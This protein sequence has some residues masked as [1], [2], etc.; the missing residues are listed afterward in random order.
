MKR[1]AIIYVVFV[2]TNMIVII[3][4]EREVNKNMNEKMEEVVQ[5]LRK[6]FRGSIEFYDVP[7]KEQYKIEYC[8]N[9]LYIV[10]YLHYDFIDEKNIKDIVLSLSISI[11]TQIHYH[12]YK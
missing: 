11:A 12:Y 9:G 1:L 3:L 4:Q 5:E 8:L 7:Y 6:K 10:K 2:S